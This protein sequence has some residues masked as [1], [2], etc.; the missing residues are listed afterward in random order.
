MGCPAY[1]GAL[2]RISA[3]IFKLVST[4]SGTNLLVSLLMGQ[5]LPSYSTICLTTSGTYVPLVVKQCQVSLS[6][7]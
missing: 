1:V 4:G 2:V 3:E 7:Y 6:L 5:S